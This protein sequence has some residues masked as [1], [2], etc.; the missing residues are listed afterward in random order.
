MNLH[1]TYTLCIDYHIYS[2]IYMYLCICI[3]IL[4]YIY[5]YKYIC[6]PAQY[7]HNMHRLP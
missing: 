5:I 1:T 2:Y 7:T 4:M 6:K 3:Y